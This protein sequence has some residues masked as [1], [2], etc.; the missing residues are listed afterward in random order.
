MLSCEQLGHAT[1]PMDA[2]AIPLFANLIFH[3]MAA[4]YAEVLILDRQDHR[5]E[6]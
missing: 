1:L 6:S 5:E 2:D 3:S 4:R